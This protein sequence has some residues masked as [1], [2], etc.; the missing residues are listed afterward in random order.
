[1]RYYLEGNNVVFPK[2]GFV[3]HC[4]FG[5]SYRNYSIIKARQKLKRSYTHSQQDDI[6]HYLKEQKYITS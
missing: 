5:E 1:M 4:S 2:H 6:I 3:F